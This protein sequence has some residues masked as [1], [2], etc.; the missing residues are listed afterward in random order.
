MGFDTTEPGDIIKAHL[1]RAT[2]DQNVALVNGNEV[3]TFQ[4]VVNLHVTVEIVTE[5]AVDHERTHKPIGKVSN[6]M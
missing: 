1:M 4:S 5:S 2:A 3:Q 6:G